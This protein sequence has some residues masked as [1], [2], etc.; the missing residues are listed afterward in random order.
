MGHNSVR[1]ATTVA[2][3]AAAL[4]TMAAGTV[5]A[6]E[7]VTQPIRT[8]G[9]GEPRASAPPTA[10][11]AMQ[12]FSVSPALFAENQG[13]WADPSVRFVHKGSGANVAMTDDGPVF[14]VFKREED[15]S[16]K[17]AGSQALAEGLPGRMRERL[18]HRPGKTRMLRFSASFVGANKV[19]PVGLQRADTVFNYHVGSDPAQWRS[20]VPT[21]EV[22]AYEGLYDGIDL[23]TWGR[24]SHLKYEFHVAPGADW[25]QISVR[26]DGIAGL[27]INDDGA[28]IVNLGDGWESII[29]DAPYVYQKID[30]RRTEVESRFVL[31]DDLT[32]TFDV[33]GKYDP[34]L[35]LVI[36]PELAWSTYLGG[37]NG[38][39][40]KGI[41]VDAS[42]VYVTG[43]TDSSGWT[44]GGFDTTFNGGYWDAFVVKLTHSGGHAWSTYL[45]GSDWDYGRSIAVDALG[46]YVT[47]E[48]NSSGWTSG[49]FDTS[50]NGGAYGAFAAKLALSGT[51]AW[52]TYLAGSG[53]DVGRGIAVDA[54]GVYV[55]GETNS[56]G[57]TSGGFD[58]SYNGGGD[59]FVMKLTPSGG[60]AWSTYIGGN[61]LD[62][63]DGIAADGSGVYV[64]G[65]TQ[66]SGWTTGG[67]D[68][69]HNGWS[70]AFVAKLTP[71]GG[72][73]W[74]TYLGGSDFD[75]GRG[76]A[77]DASGVYVT[78]TT[79]SSGWTTGGF[80]TTHNGSKD[81]FVAKL[82]PSGGLA[83]STYLG[84]STDDRGHGIAVDAP[85][86]YVMGETLSSGWTSGGFDTTYNG[87]TSLCGDAFVAKLTPCG[88]LTWSTYL[89]GKDEDRGRGIAVDGSGVYVT[90]STQSSG[91]TSGG[92][93][94]SYNGGG[95]AF[96]ARI[97]EGIPDQGDKITTAS[98]LGSLSS[99]GAVTTS[100]Q[101]GNGAYGTRDVDIFRFSLDTAGTVEIDLDAQSISSALDGMLRL[102]DAFGNEIASNDDHDG[103]DP[104]ISRFLSAGTYY[105]GVSG[106]SNSSY[107]VFRPGS[108]VSGSTGDYTLTVRLTSSKPPV[109]GSLKIA[110]M[111]FI[112][113][114]TQWVGETA[115]LRGRLILPDA[116]GGVPVT[117]GGSDY[118]DRAPDGSLTFSR[119]TLTVN[120]ALASL[121]GLFFESGL[122]LTLSQSEVRVS[123]ALDLTKFGVSDISAALSITD[124]GTGN[125][126]V[127]L[128]GGLF[129]PGPVYLGPGFSLEGIALNIDTSTNSVRGDGTLY[130]P[131]G[132][133]ISVGVGLRNGYFDY[134]SANVSNLNMPVIGYV[135][136]LQEVG[137]SMDHLAPGP[138]PVVLAGNMAF[139]AGP[140]IHVG[141]QDYYLLRLDLAAEYDTGGR[142]TGTGDVSI[143]GG[144]D[145]F[146][147]ASAIVII[148]KRYGI[149]LSGG[150]SFADV[151]EIAGALRVDLDSNVWGSLE[152]RVHAPWWLGGWTL[153]EAKVYGQY[154]NDG[155]YDNDYLIAGGKIIWKHAIEFDL[156]T[157]DI[158]WWADYD[159]LQEVEVEPPPSGAP[160]IM[161]APVYAFELPAGLDGALFQIDWE[162]GDTDIHL[163]DPFGTIYT[164]DNVDQHANAQYFKNPDGKEAYLEIDQ[165]P[166]GTWQVTVTDPNDIGGYTIQMRG[167]TGAPAITVQQPQADV[168]G[169]QVAITWVDEDS[170]SDAQ[171]SLHYDTDREGANGV[172][173]ADGI[174]EDDAADSYTWDTTGVPAGKYYVYA[175]ISDGT[176][177]P[178]ISYSTGRVVIADAGAPA[179]P[180]G[181]N[182]PEGDDASVLLNWTPPEGEV[183]HYVVR[184]TDDAAG[185]GYQRDIVTTDT[186]LIVEGL[187][188]GEAYRV[189]VAAVGSGGTSEDAEPIIVVPGGEMTVAPQGGEWDVYAPRGLTYEASL[190][191]EEGAQFSV[192]STV[193]WIFIEPDGTFTWPVLPDEG[194]GWKD[195]AVYIRQPNGET[196]VVRRSLLVD[197]AAPQILSDPAA[198]TLD[199]ATIRIAAP[200]ARDHSGPLS[201]Q[202]ERDG[203]ELETWQTNVV[204]TDAGLQPNTVYQ[205]R[206]RARDTAPDHNISAW[207]NPASV[208]TLASVPG[209]PEFGEETDISVSV[210]A[211]GADNNPAGTEYALLNV[212]TGGYVGGDGGPS[213]IPAWQA[214]ESWPGTVITGLQADT[215]YAFSF[216]ARNADGVETEPGMAALV[217]TAREA[218]PPTVVSAEVA[219]STG[220]VRLI[221][222]EPV[223][224]SLKDVSVTDSNGQPVD[225]G[226]AGLSHE[227]QGISASLSFGG[228]LPSGTYSLTLDASSVQDLSAN[229]L[230]GNGDGISGDNYVLEFTCL[231]G[232]ANGDCVVNILDLLWVRNRLNQ[233]VDSGDNWKADVNCD[234]KVDILDLITVR[235]NLNAKCAE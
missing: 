85:G 105:A 178:A 223:A 140:Q 93:D 115:R 23:H 7:I 129:I 161:E 75:W 6:E 207:S 143:G 151:L 167:S 135:V 169:G 97:T 221:F 70:D 173:I 37:S 170:D 26:Y 67:F 99:G 130:V 213:E 141:G 72:L 216:I 232:D 58:T 181:L 92:F 160:R 46:V 56:S 60:L 107:S 148:D 224:V 52:S 71:S 113:D 196:D 174:S 187:T 209:A 81:A 235:N 190:P 120:G 125:P 84:G 43:L 166:G 73:A 21:Y 77:V 28:L 150:L 131:A 226:D 211:A 94:T 206:V 18:G 146:R 40:G 74:S 76:I 134:V 153:A 9:M 152:G 233:N 47:G 5:A 123:G 149:Y 182:A 171:I 49:G 222:S 55:T 172:L 24:R 101:V 1:F 230:D 29:D 199:A 116:L 177:L 158:D 16:E 86:V 33:T 88:G 176:N 12:L 229:L 117:I 78:G 118:V 82:T 80:D 36:D 32:Y 168:A 35:P 104:F 145:P 165:A 220:S 62:G 175:V 15:G 4:C 163:T 210:V 155:D 205:Y 57:W 8:F 157:G 156:N 144:D 38:D 138:P 41:A 218:V 50:Y 112:V 191:A 183:V 42:G 98:D 179:A 142:F 106:Y 228:P 114:D 132:Y 194:N 87:G 59:A 200:E 39:Y 27:S 66:S 122:T 215:E 137:A 204:F 68:T 154:I 69:S 61:R 126:A 22:V 108:G 159:K 201:Y 231:T 184:L 64:T 225:L 44:S 128:I 20:G 162:T 79:E 214:T 2:V 31:I 127:N 227:V 164:P 109:P 48:T 186:D 202:L 188:T 13:Q 19:K 63:C 89:G 11:Q 185:E 51:H 180:T 193:P 25:R 119:T 14:E 96:V 192:V 219:Q 53:Y 198:E 195:I 45:G 100:G 54:S 3:L 10:Q 91:W 111:D 103:R 133:G 203:G 197:E 102:F 90:G 121:A 30:D 147:L 124:D 65:S 139:T 17:A 208:F 110:G 83:W 234:G 189:T 217:R 95:D 212:T 136:F 34:G